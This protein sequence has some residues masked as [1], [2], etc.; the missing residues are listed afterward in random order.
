ML[1]TTSRVTLTVVSTTS[2]TTTVR[3]ATVSVKPVVGVT[4]SDVSPVGTPSKTSTNGEPPAPNNAET[5]ATS[6]ITSVTTVICTMMTAVVRTDCGNQDFLE[7]KAHQRVRPT[8]TKSEVTVGKSSI[9]VMM[10][11]PSMEMDEIP[12]VMLRRATLVQGVTGTQ[13]MSAG[14][15]VGMELRLMG[16]LLLN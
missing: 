15:T 8:V 16:R 9:P 7:F 3:T 1:T 6:V 11:T 5:A 13:L 14:S 10:A 2:G 4:S 12:P